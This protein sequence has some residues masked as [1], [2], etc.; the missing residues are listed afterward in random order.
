MTKENLIFRNGQHPNTKI[1]IYEN[2]PSKVQ[3]TKTRTY[4][5]ICIDYWYSSRI[6][7]FM[8]KTQNKI[9]FG[10]F[11][12]S[13]LPQFNHGERKVDSPIF[14]LNLNLFVHSCSS[15]SSSTRPGGRRVAL[16]G[17]LST[18]RRQTALCRSREDDSFEGLDDG[19]WVEVEPVVDWLVIKTSIR[20][21]RTNPSKRGWHTQPQGYN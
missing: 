15:S 17:W 12:S 6:S 1:Q 7:K 11:H 10:V 2:N 14:R 5:K 9:P 3:F 18:Q 21:D 19:C 4:A 16:T 13:S 20:Q 8:F